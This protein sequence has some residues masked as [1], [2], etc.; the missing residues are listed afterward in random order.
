[1][2]DLGAKFKH[3]DVDLKEHRAK[4][5]YESLED[6]LKPKTEIDQYLKI[7]KNAKDA[8]NS[9]DPRIKAYSPEEYNKIFWNDESH[10][11]GNHLIVTDTYGE[12]R[13]DEDMILFG[14]YNVSIN[15]SGTDIEANWEPYPED[16]IIGLNNFLLHLQSQINDF[17]NDD[18]FVNE[19]MED[20]LKPK[21]RDEILNAINKKEYDDDLKALTTLSTYLFS[22]LRSFNY[23]VGYRWNPK[24]NQPYIETNFTDEV[25][26]YYLNAAKKM[27]KSPIKVKVLE[28][29]H[30]GSKLLNLFYTLNG[31]NDIKLINHRQEDLV[32]DYVYEGDYA[33]FGRTDGKHIF[34]IPDDFFT[35]MN[36]SI[37][38]IL[39]PKS[40]KQIKQ[41]F[42]EIINNS[43]NFVDATELFNPN[44]GIEF[45]R[46]IEEAC[47]AME[48]QLKD[49]KIISDKLSNDNNVYE[50]IEKLFLKLAFKDKSKNIIMRKSDHTYHANPIFKIGFAYA[51]EFYGVNFLFF[52]HPHLVNLIEK[53]EK[54]PI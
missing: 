6:I 41:D 37:E 14:S 29:G 31:F 5:V 22:D 9:L 54:L 12:E 18:R 35:K 1:M 50:A 4:F 13:S 34:L 3:K 10:E 27:G 24:N 23:V 52:D 49:V 8:I 30:R 36:E 32:F 16:P 15:K 17:D 44:S 47:N 51:Y 46:F 26:E 25:R 40:N 2:T 42:L 33:F 38:R 7:M 48:S 19:S 21:Q 39:R 11:T 53:W 43:E 20:I 28:G 45:I